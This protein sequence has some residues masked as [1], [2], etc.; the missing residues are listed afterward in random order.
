MPRET[1]EGWWSLLTLEPEVNGDSWSTYEKGSFLGW[2]RWARRDGTRDFCSALA[3][4]VSP[5]QNTITTHLF[6]KFTVVPIAQ[7]PG[8][9]AVLGRLS[10]CVYLC[11]SLKNQCGSNGPYLNVNQRK[12]GTMYII[13]IIPTVH[14]IHYDSFFT[15]SLPE[16]EGDGTTEEGGTYILAFIESGTNFESKFV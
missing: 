13:N 8:Q 7:Q 6:T 4:L 10:L 12:L 15:V 3:A 2:L 14:I 5:V 1:R 16:G 9:A 11:F